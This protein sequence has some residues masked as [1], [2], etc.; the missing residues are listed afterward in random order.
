ML[1]DFYLPVATRYSWLQTDLANST[2]VDFFMRSNMYDFGFTGAYADL[3]ETELMQAQKWYRMVIIANLGAGNTTK[4]FLNGLLVGTKV[5]LTLDNNYAWDKNGV[6]FICDEDGEDEEMDV[7]HIAIWDR[8]L[9][10]AQVAEL[11]VAGTAI[12]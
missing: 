4:Y 9:T 6:Y 10:D 11:G 12:K 5:G 3:R 2:D 7:A 1:I 8:P